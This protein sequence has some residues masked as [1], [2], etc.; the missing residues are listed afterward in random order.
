MLICPMSWIKQLGALTA[1]NTRV[2]LTWFF[3]RSCML[4]CVYSTGWLPQRTR[5]LWSNSYAYLWVM[6]EVFLQWRKLNCRRASLEKATMTCAKWMGWKAWCSSNA[7]WVTCCGILTS[8]SLFLCFTISK[9][10]AAKMT[11]NRMAWSIPYHWIFS[12]WLQKKIEGKIMALG[13][14]YS[15]FLVLLKTN[16]Q[17]ILTC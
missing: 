6:R 3:F 17:A 5:W 1:A 2:L 15:D 16:L 12:H 7:F 8:Q 14:G 11:L 13:L 10:K 4:W 9:E